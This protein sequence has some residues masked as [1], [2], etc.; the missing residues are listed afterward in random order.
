MSSQNGLQPTSPVDVVSFGMLTPYYNLVV[1]TPPVHNTAHPIAELSECIGDDASIVA[2]HLKKWGIASGIIGT[3]LGDDE[4]GRRT[5]ERLEALGIAG[6]VRL[7]KEIQTNF[8]VCVC[9]PTG[10]RTYWW[11]R[12]Q[13]VLETLATASL[14][15][16]EGARF[17]YVD[18]YDGDHILRPMKA[19]KAQGSA[20]YL[21]L[22][23]K[24]DD[25]DLLA[26]LAP[27]V[28]LCQVTTDEAQHGDNAEELADHLLSTGV[29]AAIVTM[30]S[31]GS[32]IAS[33]KNRIRFPAM[34]VELIDG[35]AAGVT[36]SA[37]IIYGR[38]QGWTLEQCGRFATAAAALQCTAGGPQAFPLPEIERLAAQVDVVKAE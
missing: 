6:E 26:R 30:A 22:E 12:D 15:L 14:A 18:W 36:Y 7:S 24:H 28:T 31:K 10:G 16:L 8:E 23:H 17:L 21:N 9:D 2:L 25:P 13:A 5:A 32:L 1:D 34:P 38:L 20:V 37:G 4:A 3:A 27:Y 35:S 29:E 19:A 11:Q 33:G